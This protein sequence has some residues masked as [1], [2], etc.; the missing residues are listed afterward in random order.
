MD[1]LTSDSETIGSNSRFLVPDNPCSIAD[2]LRSCASCLLGIVTVGCEGEE[3]TAEQMQNSGDPV[4]IPLAKK[5]DPQPTIVGSET[6]GRLLG[7]TGFK[8]GHGY[9]VILPKAA[10]YRSE[11]AVG[12]RNG[13]H[14]RR[15]QGLQVSQWPAVQDHPYRQER[16]GWA[17][18]GYFGN[19][20]ACGLGSSFGSC[21]G[22]EW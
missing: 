17:E 10:F 4:T 6:A 12:A 20:L 1:G 11:Q 16:Q 8:V 18:T 14:P 9:L 13:L 5:V 15:E 22:E 19:A 21:R 2:E 7:G 3:L